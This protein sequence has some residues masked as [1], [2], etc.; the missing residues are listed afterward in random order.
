M[1]FVQRDD[2]VQDLSPATSNP[3]FRGSILP[4]RLDIV[5]FG[6]R[7]VALRNVMTVASNFESRSR[8]T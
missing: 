1:L 5:R 2:V 4:G 6:F 3:A 8:I 7:P